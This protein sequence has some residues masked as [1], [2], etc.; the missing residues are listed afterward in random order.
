MDVHLDGLFL[1][2]TTYDYGNDYV[3]EED[4]G[5]GRSKVVVIPFVYSVV[6]ALGLLVN[7]ILLAVLALK[8]QSWSMSD[9]FILHLGLA[10]VLLLLTLPLWASQA[11]LQCGWCFRGITCGIGWAVFNMS[12]YCG[13][14]L[15]VCV[16]LDCYL[17][18]VR[19]IQL[20]SHKS[21]WF[22]HISCVF[23]WLVSLLL[24][25]P[26]WASA[27]SQKQGHQEDQT[28]CEPNFDLSKWQL[29]SRLIHLVLGFLLPVAILIFFYYIHQQLQISKKSFKKQKTVLVILA[30]VSFLSWLP[31][32]ITLIVDTFMSLTRVSQKTSSVNPGGSLKVTLMVTSALCC[33][34]AAL[35]PLIY[36]GLCGN[37]RKRTLALLRCRSVDSKGSL[38]ELGV[39]DETEP[40]QCHEGEELKQMTSVEHQVQSSQC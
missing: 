2:N 30:L 31:Y 18:I 27:V 1:H 35:R 24:S 40:G 26:D 28:V 33:A 25:I 23:I 38:W 10:D 36:M 19:A 16:T 29:A 32:N 37:F 39:G 3:Y 15:L 12:F 17:S 21:P 9:T 13:N 14:F 22:A 11:S 6:L 20:F 8:R 4:S 34:H 7:G 5:P